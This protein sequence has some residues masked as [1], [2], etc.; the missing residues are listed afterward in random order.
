MLSK[1]FGRSSLGSAVLEGASVECR[2]CRHCQEKGCMRNSK[3]FY[4]VAKKLEIF[5]IFDE[6]KLNLSI[7]T[8]GNPVAP[9]HDLSKSFGTTTTNLKVA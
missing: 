4:F 5:I 2:E 7:H 9:Q 6:S 8:D 1:L 3:F